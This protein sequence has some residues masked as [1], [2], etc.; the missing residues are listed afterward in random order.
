MFFSRPKMA[1]ATV[2]TPN[3]L[4]GTLVTLHSFLRHNPWFDGEILIIHEQLPEEMQALLVGLGK[5]RFLAVRPDLLARVRDL[6]PDYQDF[7]RR[8]AQF[9]SLELAGCTDYS[10]LL[11]LDSDLLITGSIQEL[12]DRDEPLLCCG[13]VRHYRPPV[14]AN[15]EDPFA[16]EQFNAGVLRF[17]RSLLGEK[18]YQALIDRISGTFFAPYIAYAAGHGIPRVGTDQIILNDH[19][20]GQATFMPARFNYR[21]GI[22]REIAER[23]DCRLEDALIIHYTGA[24]KPWMADKVVAQL[25][26]KRHD[27]RIFTMWTE[28]YLAMIRDL[29]GTEG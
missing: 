10:R 22:A 26:R 4:P 21:V 18:V 23:E 2:C 9:Y 24:K 11:F 5:T 17:D 3:F 1:I 25:A 15:P 19:F 7:D 8:K 13:T 28:A 16:V 27:L 20:A 6:I 12:F 14:P 29:G